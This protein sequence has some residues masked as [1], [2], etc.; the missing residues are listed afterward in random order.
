MRCGAAASAAGA[1][2]RPGA[3]AAPRTAARR[4]LPTAVSTG[5]RGRAGS[6]APPALPRGAPGRAWWPPPQ[7]PAGPGNAGC[8]PPRQPGWV[9]RAPAHRTRL[10]RDVTRREHRHH[11][12][13]G[14]D[15]VQVQRLD[16]T[17][18][19]RRQA[20]RG[21]Q[22]AGEFGDV[23][24]VGR[25]AGHVQVRRFVRH[26]SGPPRRSRGC[27]RGGVH[28]GSSTAHTDVADAGKGFRPGL[29]PEAAQQV[30]ATCWR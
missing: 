10:G 25:S 30:G 26:G 11:A 9:R 4:V 24:G 17:V 5:G 22:G 29:Q 3:W 15:G 20:Q 21:V 2:P 28:G 23:V 8:C 1:S 6:P 14:A 18:G 19:Q 16:H 7:T 12:G 27:S 13:Q